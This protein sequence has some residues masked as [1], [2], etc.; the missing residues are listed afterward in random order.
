MILVNDLKSLRKLTFEGVGSE[1]EVGD[2]IDLKRFDE[3]IGELL[4]LIL[5]SNLFLESQMHF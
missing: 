5:V 1:W 4:L 3:E 2:L